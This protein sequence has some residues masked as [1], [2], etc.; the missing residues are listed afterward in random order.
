MPRTRQ[1]K[2]SRGRVAPAVVQVVAVGDQ[3]DAADEGHGAVDHAQLLVQPARLAGLEV[4]P[5][6]VDRPEHRQLDAR[7]H[8]PFA[9]RGQRRLRAEAVHHHAHLHA[10]ARG[11]GQQ[12]RERLGDGV[13]VEDVGGQPDRVARL[14][15]R[16]AHRR[17]QVVAAAQQLDRMAALELRLDAEA[18]GRARVDALTTLGANRGTPGSVGPAGAPAASARTR[19]PSI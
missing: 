15:D 12:Q 14:R 18:P 13:V 11:L 16:R 3:V 2:S 5:P 8:H 9:Q 10:A 17:E 7:G 6:A 4:A 1:A 19:R